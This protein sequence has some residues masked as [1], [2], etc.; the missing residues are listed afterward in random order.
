MKEPP[1]AGGHYGLHWPLKQMAQQKDGDLK[2]ANQLLWPTAP[3]G[4][5]VEYLWDLRGLKPATRSAL[6]KAGIDYIG[7]LLDKTAAELQ[8][9][10]TVDVSEI[11]EALQKRNLHL[12]E[13]EPQSE[14]EP[15]EPGAE[16]G[17]RPAVHRT[18]RRPA[19]GRMPNTGRKAT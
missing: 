6:Y 1:R 5:D 3:S 12:K 4:I 14:S 15:D 2:E 9:L 18:G 7:Q 17:K 16:P 10:G 8:E 19:H 11:E 13:P